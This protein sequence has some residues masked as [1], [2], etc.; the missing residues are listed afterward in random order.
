MFFEKQRSDQPGH[1][2]QASTPGRQPAIRRKLMVGSANDP[3]EAEAD[4]MAGQVMHMPEPSLIQRK[5]RDYEEEEKNL[6]RK[7][8]APFIQQK[9][10]YAAGDSISEAIRATRGTGNKLPDGTR[11]FM[12]SR[13]EA[14]FS[15][16]SI[17]TG[18]DAAQMAQELNAQAFTV[19]NDIYFNEGKYNPDS[20]SGQHLL[21]HELAHTLQQGGAPAA[22]QKKD[23]EDKTYAPKPS[24]D[25]KLLPPDLQLRL[26][27]FLLEADTGKVHLDYQTR[28]FMAGF[29]Y[30]YGDALSL[31]MRF[32]DFTSKLG[33]T[34]GDNKFALSLKKGDLS[35]GL[36]ASPW[37]NKYGLSLH[38]GAPL[39]PAP[40]QIGSTFTAGGVSLGNLGAGLPNA[41]SDPFA[42]YQAHKTDIENVTKTADLVKKITNEGKSK[43]KFGADFSLTYDPEKHLAVT[44]KTG[45]AF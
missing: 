29:S 34:P 41:F 25:F 31:N 38:Y 23:G 36:T 30:Q 44:V 15:G 11:S 9:E 3:L 24:I 42:Y 32:N 6:Q 37:Q 19:G 8:L 10:E 14:D 5:S 7:P 16:V 27:H 45:I 4:A 43:I 28:S 20:G 40:D 35:G 33:W 2:V 21:A 1:P 12:E 22:V 13:M 26:F 17:H 18:S 39:L